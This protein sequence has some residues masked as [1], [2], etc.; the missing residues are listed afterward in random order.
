MGGLAI[1]FRAYYF[2]TSQPI[3]RLQAANHGN[4]VA[5]DEER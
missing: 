4:D 3:S 1:L 5:P 2:T